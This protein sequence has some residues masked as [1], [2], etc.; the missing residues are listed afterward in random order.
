MLCLPAS[1]ATAT[2]WMGF[3]NRMQYTYIYRY[4]QHEI[5]APVFL[6]KKIL[7]H[8][9]GTNLASQQYIQVTPVLNH[10]TFLRLIPDESQQIGGH[11]HP[12]NGSNMGGKKN[13]HH[14]QKL[15]Q[16]GGF[17][18]KFGSKKQ[19]GVGLHEHHTV[20]QRLMGS[21]GP[22]WRDMVVVPEAN[23]STFWATKFVDQMRKKK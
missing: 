9:L 8:A 22:A 17:R 11:S 1:F 13:Q 21:E 4:V 6:D 14:F 23:R 7:S 12:K 2:F 16:N 15:D 19:L 3:S 18:P 5:D 10:L 20:I